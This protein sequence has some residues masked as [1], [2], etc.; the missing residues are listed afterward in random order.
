MGRKNIKIREEERGLTV[1]VK[2]GL[3]KIT[4]T[5]HL[6]IELLNKHLTTGNLIQRHDGILLQTDHTPI[7]THVRKD[8]KDTLKLYSKSEKVSLDDFIV[9][10]GPL[11]WMG[12]PLLTKV[13]ELFEK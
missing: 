12:S 6:N 1:F 5:S 3:L 8:I 13:I 7:L 2:P 11:D 9:N 4:H 10:Y